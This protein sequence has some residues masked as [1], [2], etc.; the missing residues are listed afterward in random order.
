MDEE[1]RIIENITYKRCSRCKRWLPL[2]AFNMQHGERKYRRQ[3]YCRKCQ[4]DYAKE[5]YVPMGG[6]TVSVIEKKS[7][8]ERDSYNELFI[9]Y[10]RYKDAAE[11]FKGKYGCKGIEERLSFEYHLGF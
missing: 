6:K 5:K 10:K 4:H 7:K 1:L 3:P 11:S 2:D 9:L 8:E